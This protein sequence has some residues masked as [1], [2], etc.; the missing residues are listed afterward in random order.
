MVVF[1]A[2]VNE[3]LQNKN[4]ICEC[5]QLSCMWKINPG[6]PQVC[7]YT[8]YWFL[9]VW[10]KSGRTRVSLCRVNRALDGHGVHATLVKFSTLPAKNSPSI[11][12]VEFLNGLE[13]EISYN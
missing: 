10:T 13:S 9:S 8:C 12:E 3:N 2:N 11:L 7:V 1:D 5:N 4:I 6:S